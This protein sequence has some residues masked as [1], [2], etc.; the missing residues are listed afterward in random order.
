V[1]GFRFGCLLCIEVNF[2][3]LWMQQQ[4]LGV[5]CVPFST[6]SEDPIFEVIARGHAVMNGFWLSMA[7]PTACA[8][9]G[10]RR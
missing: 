6:H 9:A 2:P 10:P 5:D 4:F 8:P 7:M 1:D 3:E